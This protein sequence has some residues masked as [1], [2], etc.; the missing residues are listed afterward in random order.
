MDYYSTLG[1]IDPQVERGGT[2]IPATGYLIQYQRL[3]D[4]SAR[5]ELTT[6]EA[7]ILIQNFDLGELYSYEQARNLSITLLKEWLVKY[8]FKNWDKTKTRGLPVTRKMKHQRAE[9]IA[10]RLNDIELLSRLSWK[11]R[12]AF[13][14]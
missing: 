11:W 1:P 4:K 13:R 10:E 9:E 7:S 2:L 14:R 6:A 5:G 12:T 8:K 3:I